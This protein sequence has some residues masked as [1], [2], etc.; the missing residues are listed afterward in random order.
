MNYELINSIS[1][2]ENSQVVFNPLVNTI[3]SWQ[4]VIVH[5]QKKHRCHAATDT[6]VASS[7][8]SRIE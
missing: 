8:G 3:I 5:C 2:T 1:G 7:P 6:Y 4:T